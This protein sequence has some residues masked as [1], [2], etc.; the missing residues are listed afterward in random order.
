MSPEV[1]PRF[2]PGELPVLLGYAGVAIY[3]CVPETD[4]MPTIGWMLA[5]LLLIELVTRS[6]SSP[7]AQVVAAG[8]VLWSGIYGAT[9]RGSAIVGAWFAFWPLVLVV[10][11]ALV[12][13]LRASPTRWA[14][15]AI[16]AVAAVAVS[17]TGAIEPTTAPALVSVAVVAPVSLVAAWGATR[18]SVRRGA[19]ASRR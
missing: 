14:I 17:R 2:A 11:A 8:I 16:G 4:Q 3:G 7:A 18:F 12:F 19:R 6:T 9:G 1:H 10:S 13:G 15:G 5:G